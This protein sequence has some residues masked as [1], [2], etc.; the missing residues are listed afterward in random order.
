MME[1]R[2]QLNK[3]LKFVLHSFAGQF[4]L[5]TWPYLNLSIPISMRGV[6]FLIFEFLSFTVRMYRPSGMTCSYI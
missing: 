2:C 3:W 6:C 1:V 5:T 4:P